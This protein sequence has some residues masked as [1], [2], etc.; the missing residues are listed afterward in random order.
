MIV[1]SI[2]SHIYYKSP[3]ATLLFLHCRDFK[4]LGREKLIDNTTA[5]V[6]FSLGRLIITD[7]QLEDSGH[8]SCRD[9]ESTM[10]IANN[11]LIVYQE[12]QVVNI[13]VTGYSNPSSSDNCHDVNQQVFEVKH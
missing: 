11:V 7:L 3:P 12:E 13:E 10:A 1:C 5:R 2:F 6:S 9:S 8:Y 4:D